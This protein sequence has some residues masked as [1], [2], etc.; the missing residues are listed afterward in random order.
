[1]RVSLT[2]R[3]E[4]SASHVYAASGASAAENERLFGDCVRHHGHNYLLEVTVSG[5][6]DRKTGMVVNVTDLKKAIQDVVTELDHRNLNLDVPHFAK[7]NPT[8]ENIALFLWER[9]V[10]R[11]GAVRLEKVILHEDETLSAEVR[12]S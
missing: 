1:M 6:A 4:F 5:E 9:L 2:K 8:T 11:L 3:L 10:A 7:T 12:H